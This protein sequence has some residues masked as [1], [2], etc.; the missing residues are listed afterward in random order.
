MQWCQLQQRKRKLLELFDRMMK[1]QYDLAL[2]DPT[3][4]LSDDCRMINEDDM[5]MCDSSRSETATALHGS[6]IVFV[7]LSRVRQVETLEQ[8]QDLN[9]YF[10]LYYGLEVPKMVEFEKAQRAEAD[11]AEKE[12]ETEP[13]LKRPRRRDAYALCVAA[14]LGLPRLT[15]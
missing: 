3:A 13:T 1:F 4:P 10:D 2:Q 15:F 11:D 12:S 5:A 9:A 14:G 7:V 8:L 6:S